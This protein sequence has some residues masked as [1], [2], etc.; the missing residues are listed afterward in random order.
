[1][2]ID[3]YLP[4]FD[5]TLIEHTVVDADITTT[6]RALVEVDLLDVHSP[7]LNAAF[8]VR[9]LPAKVAAWRGHTRPLDELSELRLPG[10]DEHGLEGWLSLGH[11]TQHEIAFGA[12]GRFWKPNIEWYDVTAM[13]PEEFADFDEPGWGRI[14]ANF[15]V[16]PYGENRTLLSYEVRTATSDNESA[17]RFG[18][19]WRV[20]RPIVGHVLRAALTTVRHNAE[21][22]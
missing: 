3:R 12:V 20:I 22:L 16:R 17:R 2:L 10:I 13:T 14:A 1:M 15:S 6:W 8:Y 21:R 7:V 5:V 9:G 11:A 19:Y 4:E 18:R